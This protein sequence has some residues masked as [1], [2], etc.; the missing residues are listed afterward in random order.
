M[1]SPGTG[2]HGAAVAA[3]AA[4]AS[5]ATGRKRF[6]RKDFIVNSSNKMDGLR[7]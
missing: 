6:L 5:P 1:R 3:V 4:R 2:G 7:D